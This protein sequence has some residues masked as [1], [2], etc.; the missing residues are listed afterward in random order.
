MY[1]RNVILLS[2]GCVFVGSLA[3][4]SDPFVGT[5]KF[6][7]AQSKL[8]GEREIIQDLGGNQYKFTFGT[9]SWTIVA[10]GSDQPFKFGGTVSLKQ[11]GPNTWVEV[12]KHD[13]K[14]S[15][16]S[17]MTV[18][19]DGKMFMSAE[20]GSRPDGTNYTGGFKAKRISGTKGLA[21]TWESTEANADS[22]PEWVIEPNGADG[23]SFTTPSYKEK[24]DMKFDGNF[25][26]DSGPNVP[27]GSM[28]S[29]KR[30]NEKTITWTDKLKN[31]VT[32]HQELKVSDDGKTLTIN[33]RYPGERTA[34][35]LVYDRE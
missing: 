12:Q 21:G 3:A 33:I 31:E 10:D 4:A 32:D 2:L 5:W 35:T 29:A 13:G 9:V 6:D 16:T 15:S 28:S 17:N 25:Y 26:P 30:V 7:S 19:D 8:T 34:Q 18:S 24:Q 23:L 14:I 27:A 22:Y 1:S 20:N 11:T